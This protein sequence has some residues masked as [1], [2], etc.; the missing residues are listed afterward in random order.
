[1]LKKTL[2]R[3]LSMCPAAWYIFIRTLQLVSLLMLCAFALLLKAQGAEDG[4]TLRM[5]AAA[6][7]E[8][9]QAL[10]LIAVIFS[11]CLE[12]VFTRSK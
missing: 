11:V 4:Y 8:I 5:T 1:M 12:D 10:L 2:R 9:S 7:N 3:M 6:L